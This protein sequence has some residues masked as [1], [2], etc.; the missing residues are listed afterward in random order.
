MRRRPKLNGVGAY[1]LCVVV[2]LVAKVL[3]LSFAQCD[4]ADMLGDQFCGRAKNAFGQVCVYLKG[5]SRV[6]KRLDGT[7]DVWHS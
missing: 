6:V 5:I 7:D 3:R 1:G 2:I 4:A